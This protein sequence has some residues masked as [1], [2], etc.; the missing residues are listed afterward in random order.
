VENATGKERSKASDL[1]LL[2]G[3]GLLVAAISTASL[4]VI[5][6]VWFLGGT[7][8]LIFFLVVGWGYRRKFRDPNV[9]MFFVAWTVAHVLVFLLILAYL[10]IFWYLLIVFPELLVG[11]MIAGWHFGPPPDK[12]LK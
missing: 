3:T 4:W 12:P 2:I 7:S 5:S 9:V 11:Y 1:L 6:P 10:N 8:A